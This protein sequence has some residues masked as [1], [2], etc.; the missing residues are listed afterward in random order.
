MEMRQK[1]EEYDNLDIFHKILVQKRNQEFLYSISKDKRNFPF[2]IE[3]FEMERRNERSC[4]KFDKVR[5]C[6][7][8]LCM[9]C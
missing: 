9:F 5:G 2:K 8:D 6:K 3:N 1:V 4:Y 7:I